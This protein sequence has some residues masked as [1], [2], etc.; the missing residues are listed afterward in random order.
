MQY[1]LLLS[2][3]YMFQAGFPPIICTANS[4]TLVVAAGKLDLYQMLC[5]QF[6]SS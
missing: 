4:P 5:V 6:L 2:M 3:L 1:S